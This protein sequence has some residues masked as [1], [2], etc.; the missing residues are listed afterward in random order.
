MHEYKYTYV[1]LTPVTPSDPPVNRHGSELTLN[2]E[3]YDLHKGILTF[4]SVCHVYHTDVN[5]YKMHW[6][7]TDQGCITFCCSCSTKITSTCTHYSGQRLACSI[8]V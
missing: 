5:S 7:S 6:D 4:S 1:P 3:N 8:S 2:V